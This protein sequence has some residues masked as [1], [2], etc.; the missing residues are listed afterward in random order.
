MRWRGEV[1]FFRNNRENHVVR[2]EKKQGAS[3]GNAKKPLETKEQESEVVWWLPVT[4]RN[5]TRAL[6]KANVAPFKFFSMCVRSVVLVWC[7]FNN[8]GLSRFI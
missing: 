5:Q 6:L 7:L 2:S 8:L 4:V 3:V 1:S